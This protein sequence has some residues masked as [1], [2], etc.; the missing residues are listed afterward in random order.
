M[1]NGIFFL[2]G[3]P[4]TRYYGEDMVL[5]N[6]AT[7]ESKVLPIIKQRPR[8]TA[9]TVCFIFGFGIDP[10]TNDL[11]V[12]RIVDFQRHKQSQFEV[13]KLS[14]NSWRVIDRSVNQLY[15]LESA[16]F[17]SYLNGFYHWKA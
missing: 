11:K 8:Y 14:T 13:C 5:W 2:Y 16:K 17:P 12:V 7:R 10:Q 3:V 9:P 6:P 1:C 15:V 4:L